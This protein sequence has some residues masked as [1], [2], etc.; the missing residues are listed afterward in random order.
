[1]KRADSSRL[2]EKY[3]GQFVATLETSGQPVAHSPTLRQLYAALRR[4]RI[5]P[6]RTIVEK[7]PPKDAVVIYMA[8]PTPRPC[9]WV[10]K[11]S[12]NSSTSRSTTGAE[13][14]C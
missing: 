2:Y 3:P 6:T 5:D 12:L 13:A 7:V 11:D 4:K 14:S 8:L 10:G 1:M 9:C